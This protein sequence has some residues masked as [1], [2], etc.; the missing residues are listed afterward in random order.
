MAENAPFWREFFRHEAISLNSGASNPF[1]VCPAGNMTSSFPSYSVSNGMAREMASVNK[2]ILMGT[3]TTVPDFRVLENGTMMVNLQLET[4]SA[5][6]T[7]KHHVIFF[8]H[9]GEIVLQ[10]VYQDMPVYIEGRIRN[11]QYEDRNGN[12]HRVTTIVARKMQMLARKKTDEPP[13]S[14]LFGN[15]NLYKRVR[16]GEDAL[17]DLADFDEGYEWW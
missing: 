12:R 15:V 11:R 4:V 8:G 9:L 3:V 10:Y 16:D 5:G 13:V 2:V 6:E 17:P 1:F 7:E 14:D